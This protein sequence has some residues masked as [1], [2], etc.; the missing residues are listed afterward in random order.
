M[1]SS[2]RERFVV[3]QIMA[4]NKITSFMAPHKLAC[5][6]LILWG[7]ISNGKGE[8]VGILEGRRGSAYRSSL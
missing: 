7:R 2:E 5:S 3:R 4:G 6:G 8:S 1:Q